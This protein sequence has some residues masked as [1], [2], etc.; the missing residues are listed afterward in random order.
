MMQTM[1]RLPQT[2]IARV[3]GMTEPQ[4]YD[5]VCGQVREHIAH[6]DAKEGIGA[7]LEKRAPVWGQPPGQ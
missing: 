6:P 5:F 7:F 1:R 2:V 3:D 4:A